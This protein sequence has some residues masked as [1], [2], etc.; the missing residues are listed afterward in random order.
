M[1]AGAAATGELF[2]ITVR[3]QAARLVPAAKLARAVQHRSMVSCRRSSAS[4]PPPVS[5]RA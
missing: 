4:A 1:K 5:R 2:F 3:A